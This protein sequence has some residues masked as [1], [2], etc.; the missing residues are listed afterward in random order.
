MVSV[1]ILGSTGMLGSAI[2][3][4]LEND[5]E[6]VYE[7]NRSGISVTKNNEARKLDVVRDL[8]LLES[9]S[10]IRVDYI[11]NCIGMIKQLISTSSQESVELAHKTN[12]NFPKELNDYA[13]NTGVPVIQIG[14]DCVFSGESGAYTEN[15]PHDPVDVYGVTKNKG[16]VSSATSMLIRCSIIGKELE[17]SNSLLSWVLSHPKNALING[18]TNHYWNGVTT[19]HFSRIV[20]GIIRSDRFK[21]GVF[22]LVPNDVISKYELIK[23][24]AKTFDRSDLQ[25]VKFEAEKL[26]DRSLSTNN[27]QQNLSFWRAGG[28]NEIPTINEMI[29]TYSRW[30]KSN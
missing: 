2:T 4:V 22:H 25:I 6:K 3:K 28:Y 19:L 5:L 20:S 16:E 23:L 9:F 11:I 17:T 12:V 29:S 24:I 30:A 7:F 13:K 14:T 18:Y 15:Q 21:Q 1:A 27:P 8:N 26:I 10:G